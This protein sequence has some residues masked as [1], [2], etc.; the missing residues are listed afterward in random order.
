MVGVGAYSHTYLAPAL[1]MNTAQLGAGMT[2]IWGFLPLRQSEVLQGR[3]I[4]LRIVAPLLN[5]QTALPQGRDHPQKWCRH[6]LGA[7]RR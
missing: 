3:W 1:A 4:V 7:R 6:S 5:A 2:I